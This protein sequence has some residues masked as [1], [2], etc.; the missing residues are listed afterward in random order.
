V[1]A[2]DTLLA[3]LR[4]LISYSPKGS[5][6]ELALTGLIVRNKNVKLLVRLYQILAA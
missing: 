5:A 3:H 2:I 4:P 1:D 6:Y